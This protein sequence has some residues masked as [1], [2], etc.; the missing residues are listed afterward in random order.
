MKNHKR[1]RLDRPITISLLNR[2]K[3][4]FTDKTNLCLEYK[5]RTAKADFLIAKNLLINVVLGNLLTKELKENDPD[6]TNFSIECPILSQEN[7][8]ISWSRPV[9]NM[10]KREAFQKLVDK[11]VVEDRIEP[12]KSLW[13]NPVV[14]VK[15]KDGGYRFTQ[16]LTRLNDIVPLDEFQYRK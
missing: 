4:I 6:N 15:K 10:E 7:R 8:I 13:C 14:I 1:I 9:K 11:L 5:G 12:S 2:E 3:M 16:D